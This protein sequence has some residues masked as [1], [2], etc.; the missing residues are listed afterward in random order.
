MVKHKKISDDNK[1]NRE[2]IAP[3]VCFTEQSHVACM[4]TKPGALT[5]RKI[6]QIQ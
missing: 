2:Y 3:L 1:K 5:A 6:D 4:C